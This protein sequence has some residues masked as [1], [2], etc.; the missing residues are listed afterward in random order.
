M[1]HNF[2]RK[3]YDKRQLEGSFLLTYSHD[4]EISGCECV[5]WIGVSQDR[6]SDG[7]L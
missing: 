2:S 5:N 3:P 7:L 6:A 1:L 4:S